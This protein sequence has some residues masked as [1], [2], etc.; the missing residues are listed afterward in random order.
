MSKK[1]VIV[2]SPAKART[3]KRFLGSDFE[4]TAS[5]GHVRDLPE[6]SLGIDI[7]NGFEPAYT[8]TRKKIVSQLKS[9][10]KGVTDIYLA[11]D[12][13]REG[14]AIAWHLKELLQ[15]KKG[16][17]E[18][19]RVAFH[20]ITKSA[21]AKAFETPGEI[22]TSLVDSQQARRIL[23]RIVGYQVSPLLWS[24]VKRGVSAGRV[25]SVALRIICEREREIEAFEPQ[26]YWV[27]GID[28]EHTLTPAPDNKFTT[29]LV[30]IDGKKAEVHTG[31]EA[32]ELFTMLQNSPEFK[33]SSVEVKPQ[34]RNAP[35]PFITSTLQQNAGT[36]ASRTMRI[37]QQLYEGID[38]GSGGPTGL[39]TYMRTDSVAVASEAQ[40]ACRGFILAEYGDAYA[41]AKQRNFKV[42]ASAQ[43]AHEAIRPTDVTF[44]PEKAAKFLDGDQLRLYTMIWKRFVA[45]QM[46][47]ARL[48]K[49]TVNVQNTQGAK[50]CTF[51]AT[52][53]VTQFPGFMVLAGTKKEDSENKN[54]EVLGKISEG[55]NCKPADIT[56]E[57]KF[58]EPPPRYSEPSLI[59]EL[60]SNGI[61]RPSTYA[62]IVM[63]IQT[64]D[65]CRKD[66]GKLV[67]TEIG[68]QV[69]DYLVAKL[70][71][72]FEIGFTAE[73]EKQLDTIEEGK[74]N[75]KTMLQNFYDNFAKWLN[76]AK[77]AG[78]PEN[79][80][81]EALL[82]LMENVTTWAEPEK[83]G[84]RTY[85]DKK[86]FTSL[87]DQF[88]KDKS[89]TEKQWGA[90]LQL[91]LKYKEQ[92]SGFDDF[93][94]E[95][96][97]ADDV[98]EIQKLIDDRAAAAKQRQANLNSEDFLK[99]KEAF[100]LFDNVEWDE[101]VKKGARTFDDQ[102]FFNSL[103]K[104]MESGKAL[105]E[106]QMNAFRRIA[107]KYA[108]KTGQE[109]KLNSLLKL[110]EINAAAAAGNPEVEALLTQMANV[111]KWA[112]P[113]TKGKRTFD[114]KSF[115]ESLKKQY[116][117]RKT[118]SS[119]QIF[120]LKK[121]AAKYAEKK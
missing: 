27:F 67:P 30:K 23:D 42:S 64:R 6:K 48:Q 116:N 62:S 13:D 110:D 54:A 50:T 28:F 46:A 2:E 59:R 53:I 51:Q 73:M 98:A 5:M 117:D 11:P 16:K 35:P 72:L 70:P 83:S 109:E 14:E 44:T 61:G 101:P 18:F 103:K 3:I 92:I 34:T 33:V 112:E 40:N 66:G 104:Q 63:T 118:L 43:A 78:A 113:V 79:A 31:E 100:D 90:L 15:D 99:L 94:T 25:Q 17:I 108:E 77:F 24:K 26:E 55:D 56:K 22:N 41:P 10:A 1:L 45:S 91:A 81:A 69:N 97:C 106:K 7:Q 52:A 8:E 65:Y 115:F 88:E 39:I 32:L 80:K 38:I 96:S 111:T 75:W 85:D 4:I 119:R 71:V 20:E 37:A 86:F 120:A 89:M 58:T 47:P 12:P 121:I 102:K 93:V 36:S 105:S 82:A 87:K 60:E 49:T 107:S 74:L 57:Q 9:S 68:F 29:K 19:H 21:V 84:R 114:D 95:F 76:D